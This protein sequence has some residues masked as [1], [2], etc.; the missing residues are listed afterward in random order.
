MLRHMTAYRHFHEA[1]RATALVT[2]T[3]ALEILVEFQ[4]RVG[5]E[6]SVL[7]ADLKVLLLSG[8]FNT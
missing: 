6:P 1:R 5:A 8:Y 7:G 2:V 4:L 3:C